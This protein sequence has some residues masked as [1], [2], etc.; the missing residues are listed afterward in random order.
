MAKKKGSAQAGGYSNGDG[1]AARLYAWIAQGY[2]VEPLIESIRK[3]DA[4]ATDELFGRYGQMAARLEGAKARLAELGFRQGHA[5]FPKYSSIMNDPLEAEALETLAASLASAPRI[6]ELRQELA[7]L[8][9][10]GFEEDAKKVGRMLDAGEDPDLI[11]AE[12]RKLTKRIK[13]KFFED[14]FETETVSEEAPQ[15]QQRAAEPAKQTHFVAETIFL[16]HRDGTLLSVKSK[17]PASEI[18]K[19]LMSR[20]VMAIREQMSRAFKEG[21]HVH[22]LTYEGHTIILED[23]VHI[24]AAVVVVGEPRAVMYKVILKALQI[25]EKNMAQAF[26]S[27]KGDRNSLENLDKYTSAIFQALEKSSHGHA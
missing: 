9:T 8:N 19:K 5:M 10:T 13:E 15:A 17:K 4:A 23:S 22:A 27:W 6:T 7:S 11:E 3:G 12:L 18:D 20:M 2:R 26:D 24:Y 1:N 25:M 16:M 21:E 14:A